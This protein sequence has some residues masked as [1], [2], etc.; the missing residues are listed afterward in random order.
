MQF[1]YSMKI[2]AGAPAERFYATHRS[3]KKHYFKI[4]PVRKKSKA[5][6]KTVKFLMC[7]PF[8]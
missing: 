6:K 7:V 2:K 8:T 4:R 3:F 5:K 1:N